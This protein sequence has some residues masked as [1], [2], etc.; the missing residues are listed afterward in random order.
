MKNDITAVRN[1]MIEGMERLL[2]PEEG[3]QFDVEKAEAL[4]KLG[5]VIVD[6]AKTEVAFLKV[7]TTA[8][9]KVRPTGFITD[10][11]MLLEK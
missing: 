10:N 6:S 9:A 2:N 5:K 3:D 11:T 1:L 4:A 7:A 8:G